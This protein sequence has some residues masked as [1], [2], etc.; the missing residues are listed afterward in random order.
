M[1]HIYSDIHANMV[2]H[3]VRQISMR[4]MRYRAKQ[5]SHL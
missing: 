1:E 3:Y 2:G 5:G 4:M